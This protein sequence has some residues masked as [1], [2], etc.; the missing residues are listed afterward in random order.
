MATINGTS[1]N[2]NLIGTDD[3]DLING[4]DGNDTL[5]GGLAGADTLVGGLGDDTYIIAQNK[6]TIDT[7]IE[8]ENQGTDTV[9]SFVTYTL[10]HT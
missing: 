6:I 1:N 7:I 3:D 8:L 2:D 5:E 10:P 4:L 9:N